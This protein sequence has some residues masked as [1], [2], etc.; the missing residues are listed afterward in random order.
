MSEHPP[1]AAGMSVHN[2]TPGTSL[3][4][5]GISLFAYAM[6][7]IYAFATRVPAGKL[8]V[9]ESS[10]LTATFWA[11]LISMLPYSAAFVYA[12]RLLKRRSEWIYLS[13]P[14][15]M[16]GFFIWRMIAG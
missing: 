8:R 2:R 5:A 6:F 12:C 15:A 13:G 1:H 14:I 11:A 7:F 4:P 9:F 16:Y 3:L 10:M